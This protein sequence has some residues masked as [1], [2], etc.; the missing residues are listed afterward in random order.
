[1]VSFLQS[2]RGQILDIEQ[3]RELVTIHAKMPFAEVIKGF[4]NDLRSLTQG[5]AIWYE[6]F[7]GYEKLP[8]DL[9]PK[10]VKDIRTRKGLPP[11]PPTPEQ[12]LE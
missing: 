10:V 1:M 5:R 6:E 11:E 12:F 4:S 2:K 8:K 9:Q 7:A 3:D